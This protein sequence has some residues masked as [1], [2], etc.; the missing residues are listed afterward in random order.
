[1]HCIRNAQNPEKVVFAYNEEIR[2]SLSDETVSKLEGEEHSKAAKAKRLQVYEEVCKREC[3]NRFILS[4]QISSRLHGA[5]AFFYFRRMFTQQ[6]AVDCLLQH[7][8]AV[9]D[10]TPARVVIVTNSGRV[11]SPD[12]RVVSW[13]KRTSP[14]LRLREWLHDTSFSL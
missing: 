11:L 6:W 13:W 5:E 2:Q 1:M 14:I 10:R 8:F 4:Q 9:S 7:V 3:K 12:A